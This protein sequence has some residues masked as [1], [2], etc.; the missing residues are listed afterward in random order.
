M[1]QTTITFICKARGEAPHSYGIPVADLFQTVP[2]ENGGL[3]TLHLRGFPITEKME[4]GK[5][6]RITVEEVS[7]A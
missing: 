3:A 6:Y 7:S 1:L 4:K 5:T 2:E